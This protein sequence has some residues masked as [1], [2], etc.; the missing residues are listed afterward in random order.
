MIKQIYL[1]P[2]ESSFLV[3]RVRS[4]VDN[5]WFA[6]EFQGIGDTGNGIH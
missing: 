6:C 2:I 1:I 3:T 4:K 5:S